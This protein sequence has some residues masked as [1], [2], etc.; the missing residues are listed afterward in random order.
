MCMLKAE[1]ILLE[2]DRRLSKDAEFSVWSTLVEILP[3]DDDGLR[4]AT[5]AEAVLASIEIMVEI[6]CVYVCMCVG[7]YVCRYMY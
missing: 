5:I 1:Q 6:L 3:A 7:V 4:Q 2:W